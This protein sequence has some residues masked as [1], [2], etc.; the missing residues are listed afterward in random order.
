MNAVANAQPDQRSAE[1]YEGRKGRITASRVGSILGLSKYK[2]RAEVLREM[3]RE[4]F[5]APRE[6]VGNEAT[7]YGQAHEADALNAYEQRFAVMVEPCGLIPHPVHDFLAA[8]P[9]GL[10]G[11][12]GLVECKCPFRSRYTTPSAEYIAQ[13][14][15][16]MACTDRDWCDFVIWRE[17]EPIIVERVA[18]DF[19][20]LMRNLGNL[21]NFIGEYREIIANKELAAPYLADKERDDE[22][23]RNVVAE[24][25]DAKRHA[26]EAAE[27]EKRARADLVGLAPQGAKGCGITVSRVET[28]GRI[29]YKR[30]IT[31]MLPDVDLSPFKGNPSVSYRITESR[32]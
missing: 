31:Q 7:E 30:A 11:E 12:H 8:S 2:T 19:D 26:D 17:G 28:E 23:W 16:Q 24:W 6:F 13:M 9:D 25:R 20:W 32:A 10:V 15:L 4:H 3:V 29:D 14:Q 5:D 1:W 27:W 22:T 21:Q 18:Y